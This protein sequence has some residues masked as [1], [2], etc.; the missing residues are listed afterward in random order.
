MTKD[1]LARLKSMGFR[2]AGCWSLVDDRLRIDFGDD[3]LARA[4]N[5]LYA[6][7]ANGHVTY[8]GKS[9]QKVR[10]RMGGYRNPGPTQS[11][12]I[13]NNE[14]IRL[15]RARGET[16]ELFVLP[17]NGLL[18]YGGFH[19]NLAAGLEDS[20]IRDLAPEWNG[21]KKSDGSPPELPAAPFAVG[22]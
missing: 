5:F 15:A 2:Q 7:V 19:V 12:N 21:G 22:E 20:L 13:R 10:E 4:S 11:T 9:T 1:A 8:I 6:F 18:Y 16:V 14:R 17:D 3:E